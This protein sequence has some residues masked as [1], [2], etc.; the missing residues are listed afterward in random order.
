MAKNTREKKKMRK[1]KRGAGSGSRRLCRLLP[2]AE[3]ELGRRR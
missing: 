1:I 2:E 3:E